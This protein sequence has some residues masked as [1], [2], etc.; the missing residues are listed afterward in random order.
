[1]TPRIGVT[2]TTLANTGS[3]HTA[4]GANGSY[5]GWLERAGALPVLIPNL[6][7][8]L[9]G[10]YLDLLDGLLLTGGL[11]VHPLLFGAEPDKNLGEVDV[12][13]DRFELPLVRQALERELPIF[14][15]CR[16]IQAL[17]VAAGGT[18]RQDLVSDPVARLQHWQKPV[19]GPMV[20]HSVS[21]EP[22]SRLA[23]VVGQEKVAVNS[24]HHQAVDRVGEGLRAVGFAL[25]GTIEAVEGTGEAF[26][27]GVQWHPE[28]MGPED[29]VSTALFDAF[30]AACGVGRRET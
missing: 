1:M 19:G 15:I 8:E 25:D 10:G 27:L 20:H 2:T 3:Y 14:G 23:G 7:P 5:L 16:G 22:D 28:V 4:T 12:P 17:N 30:V 21:V 11:D 9:A 18:L 13:R 24:Y 29:A 26:V 6:A